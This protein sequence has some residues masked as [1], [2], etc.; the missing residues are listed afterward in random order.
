MIHRPEPSACTLGAL[1]EKRQRTRRGL[2]G[3]P[4]DPTPVR[5]TGNPWKATPVHLRNAEILRRHGLTL[6]QVQRIL[7]TYTRTRREIEMD[8]Q[9]LDTQ[10][11]NANGQPSRAARTKM[12]ASAPT[13]TC[14]PPMDPW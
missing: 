4:D 8:A 12:S 13:S 11:Q 9:F 10:R 6:E 5:V 14:V 3:C 2:Q 7:G 1:E